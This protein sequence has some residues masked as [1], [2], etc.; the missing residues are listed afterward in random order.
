MDQQPDAV[1]I[2]LPV[3]VRGFSFEDADGNHVVVVNSRLSRS[4]NEKTIV[5]SLSIAPTIFLAI[6]L[7][8]KKSNTTPTNNPRRTKT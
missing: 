3:S 1:L 8:S 7:M 5:M 4:A 2:D 6:L